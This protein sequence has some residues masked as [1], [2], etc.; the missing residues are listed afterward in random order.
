MLVSNTTLGGKARPFNWSVKP[1]GS[2]YIKKATGV[3]VNI[4]NS[5]MESIMKYIARRNSFTLDN[6]V[7]DIKPYNPS[8]SGIGSFM[9]N[10]LNKDKTSATL[11]HFAQA[12]S[13]L[14]SILCNSG[15]I[16]MEKK[17]R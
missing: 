9:R 5:E 16:C 4:S 12:S 13:Q 10:K 3:E 8:T 2:I 14:M 7:S 1:D 17:S 11:G 15:I 6:S